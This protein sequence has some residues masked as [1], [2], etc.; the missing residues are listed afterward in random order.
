M[1]PSVK[2]QAGLI[3][4]LLDS[5]NNV[6][7]IIGEVQNIDTVGAALGLYLI[8]KNEGKNPQIISK[9]S[10]T[11]EVS[12]LF[13]VDKISKSFSGNTKILTV[14]VPYRDGEIEKVS[15]NIEGDRLKVNLFAE[16]N[17]ISF[18]EDEIEYIRKGSEP[19]VLFTIGV[20][21]DQ[22]LASYVDSAAVKAIVIDSNP[23]NTAMGEIVLV[24]PQASSVSEIVAE[25]VRELA[26]L[27]DVDAFQNLMDGISFATRNFTLPTTSAYAF[28][29]AGYLLKNG[30]KRKERNQMESDNVSDRASVDRNRRFDSRDARVSDRA[31]DR[32][33]NFPNEDQLIAPRPPRN[34]FPQQAQPMSQP[35]Q[36]PKNNQARFPQ[37]PP[38]NPFPAVNN[39]QI[40]APKPQNNP[41]R[42]PDL[43]QAPA[44]YKA[45]QAIPN[46]PKEASG[47]DLPDDLVDA[48]FTEGSLPED[49]PDD[50]F[51]PKVFKGTKKGN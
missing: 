39:N 26:L 7:I 24:D 3:R 22:E 10:P 48:P 50:W 21:T 9:K 27:P 5:T 31:N 49:I 37:N 14:S 36:Q 38:R 20:Q 2:N 25:I 28:D 15:Y 6:G 29:A 13:G 18:G 30:A 23:M 42:T 35:Q 34:P 8:L 11:V 1:N 46:T 43:N 32:T 16:E 19:A 41:I 45:P 17:G 12:N 33:R 40:N 4:E 51:L 47:L 44:P